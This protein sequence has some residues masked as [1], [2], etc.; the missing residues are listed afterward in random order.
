MRSYAKKIIDRVSKLD[1][2]MLDENKWG[3][4]DY[5]DEMAYDYDHLSV[6]GAKQLTHR[7]DSVLKTLE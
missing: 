2:I 3:D 1:L 4:H 7:V 6:L 5:T